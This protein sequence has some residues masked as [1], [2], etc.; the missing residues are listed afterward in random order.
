MRWD[1]KDY[2]KQ[3]GRYRDQDEIRGFGNVRAGHCR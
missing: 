1:E 3:R 2:A